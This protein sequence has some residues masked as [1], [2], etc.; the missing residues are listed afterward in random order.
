[1]LETVGEGATCKVKHVVAKVMLDDDD[2][3]IDQHLAIKVYSKSQM[4]K[5]QIFRPV[6]YPPASNY[7]E[8]ERE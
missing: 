7:T 5:N 4:H 3:F 2:E 6:P 1:M 8:V